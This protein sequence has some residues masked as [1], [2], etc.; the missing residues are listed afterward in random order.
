MSALANPVYNPLLAPNPSGGRSTSRAFLDGVIDRM[1]SIHDQRGP[2]MFAFAAPHWRTGTTHVVNLVADELV[3]R[4]RCTVAVMPTTALKE[5]E[6]SRLPQGFLERS[7]GVYAAASDA[8]L[9]LLS[10]LALEKVWIRPS[11]NDFDF[12][13]A[14]CPPL[15][16]GAQ[17]LRWTSAASGVFLVVGAGQT[18]VNQIEE[19]QRLLKDSGSRLE[20]IVLNRR[21]Y[22]IPELLYKLL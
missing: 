8:E 16:C 14:D 6:P 4:Y 1:V 2:G 21:S 10:E 12:I 13:L 3:R 7:P 9:E 18:H 22:P 5:N 19:S 11:A 15:L 20:G 17:A